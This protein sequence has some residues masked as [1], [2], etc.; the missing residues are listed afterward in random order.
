M[1][2]SI[3]EIQ[4]QLTGGG[5]RNS[6]FQVQIQNPVDPAADLKVPFMVKA[7]RLPADTVGVIEVPYFGRKIKQPGDRVFDEWE[8]IVIN[9]EDFLVRNAM[10][11][12]MSA[13][14][15]HEENVRDFPD[16]S[17]LR[18]KSQAQINQYGKTGQLIRTYTFNGLWPSMIT[19]IDVSWEDTDR[20]EEFAVTFQ[21]DWWEVTGGTTGTGG[22]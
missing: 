3:N 6:L 12:W 13:I 19:P 16:S 11:A 20:I 1:A 9:D 17:P 4:A 10:E 14:N 8:V 22:T 2:F 5:A 18:L 15:K 7:S 21:Y